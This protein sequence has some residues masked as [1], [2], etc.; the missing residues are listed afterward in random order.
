MPLAT[1]VDPIDVA[2]A[3][4]VVY[5][6]LT[7]G[8]RHPDAAASPWYE[9]ARTALLG[10]ARLLDADRRDAAPLLP[11]ALRLLGQAAPAP[12][13]AALAHARLFGHARGEVCPFE[14]E[15]GDAGAHRQPNELADIAGY[16]LAFGL[17]P[18]D[19]ADE[20]A[21][22]VACECEFMDFL[23]RKE[24][25]L[26][27]QQAADSEETLAAV[28]A[29]ARSFL[30]DHLGRFGRA[31]ATRL[32]KQGQGSFGALGELL[33]RLLEREAER[34]R[35]TL[36]PATLELRPPATDD[37]PMACGGSCVPAE[38]VAECQSRQP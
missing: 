22:H 27:A 13:A 30:R 17:R 26:L 9:E 4:S 32:V 31:F 36:G 5:R 7:L 24:A 18:V 20:R 2:L 38:A 34:F 14:T 15:Y 33:L 35:L 25:Y 19:R 23:G 12:A 6:A 29:A 16:Y 8:L 3:R 37:V 11:A 21:D 1:K 28:R 10:A